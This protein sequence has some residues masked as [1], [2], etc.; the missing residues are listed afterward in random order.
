MISR[1]VIRSQC[2]TVIKVLESSKY[3]IALITDVMANKLDK[4]SKSP[5]DIV[6]AIQPKVSPFDQAVFKVVYLAA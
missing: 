1:Y 5:S 2:R 3:T 6:G 4:R